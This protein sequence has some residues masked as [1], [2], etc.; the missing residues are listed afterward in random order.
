MCRF[1]RE[2]RIEMALQI[3][4]EC[5]PLGSQNNSNK[6]KVHSF[7]IHLNCIRLRSRCLWIYPNTSQ[8]GKRVVYL[9]QRST[10]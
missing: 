1:M 2:A 5:P 7:N 3:L 6:I 4:L 8:S 10:M 9:R